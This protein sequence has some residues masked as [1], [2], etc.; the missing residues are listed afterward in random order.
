VKND[1]GFFDRFAER[2]DGV[3]SRAPFFVICAIFVIG[4]LAGLPFAGWDNDIYHLLLNSPT[5]AITFLMVSMAA[6]AARRE[7]KATNAKLDAIA[8]ALADLLDDVGGDGH[9]DSI[10]TLR[11]SVGLEEKISA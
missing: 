11:A 4:W 8:A 6:N 1:Q 10:A 2:A 7:S 3:V 5:T 9:D